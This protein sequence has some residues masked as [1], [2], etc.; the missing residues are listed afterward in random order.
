MD[1]P[2]LPTT[3]WARRTGG[4]AGY[5]HS[6]GARAFTGTFVEGLVLF[7]QVARNSEVDHFDDLSGVSYLGAAVL[8]G[9]QIATRSGLF[10]SVGV[11]A[12]YTAA[13]N[14]ARGQT[15]YYL[16]APFQLGQL[17]PRLAFGLGLAF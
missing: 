1:S 14:G 17:A 3:E 16:F 15:T 8:A 10:A 11:G 6:F 12:Q 9:G 7:D 2:H 13:L 4:Y 5:R